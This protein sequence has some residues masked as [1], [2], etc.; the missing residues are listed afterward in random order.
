MYPR[1]WI[2]SRP[3]K[4]AVRFLHDFRFF[5]FCFLFQKLMKQEYTYTL[6]CPCL[7]WNHKKK[8]R[9]EKNVTAFWLGVI[10]SAK[11]VQDNITHSGSHLSMTRMQQNA[12]FY[13]AIFKYWRCT[14]HWAAWL[15]DKKKEEMA[16]VS[17]CDGGKPYDVAAAV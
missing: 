9:K 5:R 7:C 10:K 15:C 13:Y 8:K 6:R 4:E 1:H 14:M 17:T 3:K 2:R 12:M 16:V 11:Y